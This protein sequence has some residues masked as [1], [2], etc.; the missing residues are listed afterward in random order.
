MDE[1]LLLSSHSSHSATKLQKLLIVAGVAQ[2]L[3]R[4]QKVSSFICK[5]RLAHLTLRRPLLV[6]A[7]A[8][9]AGFPNI[10]HFLNFSLSTRKNVKLLLWLRPT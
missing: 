3:D 6:V 2:N 5:Y 8:R 9:A 4:W 10:S 7:D 1:M